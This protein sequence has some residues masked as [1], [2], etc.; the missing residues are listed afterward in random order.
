MNS[1]CVAEILLFNPVVVDVILA[2]LAV[3]HT[4]LCFDCEFKKISAT[5]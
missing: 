2:A 3:S 5:Y 1:I 4:V